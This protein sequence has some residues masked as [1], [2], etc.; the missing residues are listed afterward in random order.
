MKIPLS[1]LKEYIKLDQTPAELAKLLTM[2]GIEVDSIETTDL[3]FTDVVVG[4]VLQVEKHPN[5]DKLCVAKVTDGMEV[6]QVVCGAPNCRPGIKVAFAREGAIFKEEGGKEFRIKKTK[7]RGVDSCGM[8]CSGKELHFSEEHEGI[9][10]LPESAV[11]GTPLTEMYGDTI[12]EVSFTPNLSYCSSVIG[13]ARELAAVTKQPLKWPEVK[14][15][16]SDQAIEDLASVSVID[17]QDCPRYTCRVVKNVKV[18][19]SPEWLKKRLEQSGLRSINN[20]VDVTN[21]VL[22]EMGHPLHAFDYHKVEGHKIIV[23]RSVEGYLFTTLDEKE[24]TLSAKNLMIYDASQPIAIAGVMGGGNSEVHEETRHV[25]LESAYFDPV[26]VRRTSKQLAL[27]TDSSKRFERGTDPNQLIVSLNRAA[28]LIKQVAGGEIVKGVIDVKTGEFPP[29]TI[30]C[31]LSR[32]NQLLGLTLSQGEV[33]SIFKSLQFGLQVKDL[34]S[35]LVSVPTYRVDIL[36]E[37]DLIEEVARL[38]GYD[39]IQRQ[40]G[41]YQSSQLLS[42]PIYLFEQELRARLIGEGLQEFLTCD[43]IGPTLLNIVQDESLKP[44]ILIQ[45]LNPTSIEQSILRTSLLPGLLEVVKYNIDH[46]NHHI[47][48]FGIGRIHFK[49]AEQYIEQAVMGIILSG[50]SRPHH[51]DE[52]AKDYDFYDLKGIVEDVLSALGIHNLTFKNLGL[53][54]FHS[55]RQAS[56]FVDSAEVGSIGEIHP[57]ILRRL[58]VP[59][60]ILFGEFNL[61][62]LMQLAKRAVKV[63]ELALYPSSDRDWTLT[64]K[65]TVPFDELKSLIQKEAS[66]LLEELTLID[67]YRHE[68]IGKESQNITLRFVYRDPNKTLEQEAVEKEHQRLLSGVVKKLGDVVKQ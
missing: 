15:K 20:V 24:R 57:A 61:E 23:K 42:S 41:T 66:S 54:T 11:E 50:K 46:Q 32:I 7:L 5:A 52:K 39:N 49:D 44:E 17:K 68:K 12:F 36:A 47:G 1:W 25:L 22:L 19:P 53:K 3:G 21:Y 9:I 14:I 16:E 56:I 59:Q 2:A 60:R 62:D 65:S 6:F 35:W 43:L 63:K 4:K 37:I 31:R 18:G 10:E 58:D 45:V 48:G 55:G 30:L 40:G 29:K 38:Y 26:S 64:I 8:L 33:E 27:Q 67:I 28:Q 51:W 13:V 34:D